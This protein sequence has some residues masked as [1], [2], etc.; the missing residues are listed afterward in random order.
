[1][2]TPRTLQEVSIATFE[3][4]PPYFCHRVHVPATIFLPQCSCHHFSAF[5]QATQLRLSRPA[6]AVEA[7]PVDAAGSVE[8]QG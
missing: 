8:E 5:L 2:I 3:A 6:V 7:V 1:M 4:P